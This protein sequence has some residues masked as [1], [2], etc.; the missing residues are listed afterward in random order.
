MLKLRVNFPVTGLK[1]RLTPYLALHNEFHTSPPQ[2]QPASKSPI[3]KT[4][5]IGIIAHIDAG[6]TTTT[7]RML[8]YSG[9]TSRIGNVDEGDT[10]TDY[11]PSER[12]R[13]ITIQLAAISIPWNRH[14]I[15]IIDTP[16]HADFTF[17]VTRSLRVLDGAVTILDA[18]AGVE[19]QTE[20]VWRQ[21]ASL[22]IP[23]IAYVNKMDRPGAGFSRTVKEIISKLHARAV[24]VNL[25]YF[26]P[27]NNTDFEFSGVL[28]VIYG[29]LL[30]WDPIAD[31]SGK[32]VRAIDLDPNDPELGALHEMVA[33]SRESM[34]ETLGEFDETVI[35]S[36]FEHED[37]MKIPPQVLQ[38]AIKTATINNQITPVLCGSSF[39]NM[40]VQP[41]LDAVVNY[42]PSPLQ[43][44]L[45][46]V[47]SSSSKKIGKKKKKKDTVLQAVDVPV[48]IIDDK[49]LVINKNH[50]LT[51][52]LAFKVVTH[53][54]RGV[55]TF[56]RVY[57]G[58]LASNSTVLNTRTG[59]KLHLRKLMLMHGDV[60]EEV[61][62]ISAGNIGVVA[63]T[64]DDIV[65]GDTFVSQ[66]VTHSKSFNETESNLMLHAIEIPPP[67]FNSGIEPATAG[68]ERYMNEC[69]K[70]LLREDPSLQVHVDEDLGQTVLSG[71][72]ELHL[73]IIR[74]RLVNDMKAKVRLRDVA[75]SY[76]ETVSR[77]DGVACT[78]NSGENPD[79]YAAVSL[80][81]FEGD[82]ADS[83]FAEEEG[84][85]LLPDN[86]IVILDP[87][88][89][90]ASMTEA[91]QERRWKLDQSL[92]E[93]QDLLVQGCATGLQIGG[94]TFGLPLHSCV[95]RIT[96]WNFP[97]DE[98]SA[99]PASLLDVGRRAVSRA[100]T[101]LYDKL[102]DS[103]CVLEPIM[104]TNVY[105]ESDVL[106]EVV[107]DLNNRCQATILSI[108]D[109]SE[110]LDTQNW[111]QDEAEKIY[112][113]ADYTMKALGREIKNK[114]T[115]V[116]ETPLR[117]MIGY[118]S[119][120][121]SIT[122][123]RGMFDMHYQGMRRAAKSR[124][125]AIKS[126]FT[127]M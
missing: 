12:E 10:V 36:F 115:I 67:L 31:S 127:F 35:E 29:K 53:P 24:C 16:G 76:K 95:V 33:K 9:K 26:K 69:I 23:R 104:T 11:L 40:G 114:K 42:L 58:K 94:P 123:G 98:K 113:P 30:V 89:T 72:G 3:D 27:V 61:Q 118:L 90:P 62:T 52:A 14:N 19:A 55:M 44:S 17:E 124:L 56:F 5:N 2:K 48:E 65:T 68:D 111:A 81:S 57:S 112:L 117:E 46:E 50:N 34:V 99:T 59:K 108:D 63:G 83:V 60:P 6:K 41:L 15:N 43:T 20:K 101:T 119:R 21:A 7:E 1:G 45:P 38:D 125:S 80:D 102:A 109:E 54:T 122:Q 87:S 91:I 22:G 88:A 13:G 64:D 39:R 8:Y 70:T 37:Y 86:N 47:T 106:G 126:E 120:L 82:A 4:R 116:A 107:H 97:V 103:F 18:V 25:P 93:L 49:G 100:V 85:V 92:E 96:Q 84:A 73:E 74:D 66:G 121:R 105:V 71:M 51:V 110:S 75:V 79:V 32:S 78:V 77:P 28:D